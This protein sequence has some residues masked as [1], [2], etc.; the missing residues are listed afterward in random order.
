MKSNILALLFLIFS[1]NVYAAN[2]LLELNKKNCDRISQHGIYEVEAIARSYRVSM[3]SV[4]FIDAGWGASQ[5]GG[6]QCSLIFDTPKGPKKCHVFYILTSDKGKT[7]FGV[8][9][10]RREDN[11]VCF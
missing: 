6:E 4:K 2:E 10:V 8:S 7:L 11:A 1:E 3:A 5:Y 9:V